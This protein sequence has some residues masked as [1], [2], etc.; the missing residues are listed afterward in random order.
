MKNTN[1]NPVTGRFESANGAHKYDYTSC[2]ECKRDQTAQTAFTEASTKGN[3]NYGFYSKVLQKPFDTLVEL[4]EAEAKFFEAENAKKKAAEA[5]KADAAKVEDAFKKLNT[6]KRAYNEDVYTAK[7]EYLAEVGAAKEKL[8]KRLE[9]CE[10]TLFVANK[11]YDEALK[12][13]T[14]AHPEGYHVTLRDEDNVVTIS[15]KS[16][17]TEGTDMP[18]DVF[19]LLLQ[20][21][22]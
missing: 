11:S 9:T 12:E 3:S 5:K 17:A 15:S 10:E 20:M 2:N 8:N 13:F 22:R 7:K 1:R 16:E 19:N 6:A 4:A 14:K 21:L 18:T